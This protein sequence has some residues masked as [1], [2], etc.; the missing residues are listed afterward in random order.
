V[1]ADLALKEFI[2]PPHRRAV[3]PCLAIILVG[4]RGMGGR[5]LQCGQLL[6]ARFAIGRDVQVDLIAAAKKR[7]QEIGEIAVEVVRFDVVRL[8]DAGGMFRGC[9]EDEPAGAMTV[10]QSANPEFMF[11]VSTSPSA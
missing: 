10:E 8:V 1:T 2:A 7:G 4:A 6:P 3:L 9:A 11:Q 5:V